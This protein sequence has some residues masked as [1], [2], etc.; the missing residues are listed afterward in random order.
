MTRKNIEFQQNFERNIISSEML[1][2]FRIDTFHV[3][4]FNKGSSERFALLCFS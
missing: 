3:P 4:V 2:Q 1:Y